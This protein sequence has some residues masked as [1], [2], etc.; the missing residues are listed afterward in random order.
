MVFDPAVG[1]A[2]DFL[3]AGF[4]GRLGQLGERYEGETEG[5]ALAFFAADP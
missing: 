4:L 1:R 2:G 5:T 3:V